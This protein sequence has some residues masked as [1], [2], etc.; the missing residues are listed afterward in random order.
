MKINIIWGK[1]VIYDHGR[2]DLSKTIG[3]KN[4]D[5]KDKDGNVVSELIINCE[6]K[7]IV[8]LPT[9]Y[10][11]SQYDIE[12]DDGILDFAS[13]LPPGDD[14][15][16]SDGIK[17]SELPSTKDLLPSD[18]F[19]LS[20]DEDGNGSYDKTLHVTF[21][22]LVESITPTPS[23]T[24]TVND[25][26]V[27][28]VSP[29]TPTTYFEGSNVTAQ[30]N[31]PDNYI[32]DSWV[33]DWEELNGNQS[34]FLNFVMPPQDITL[35]P[36]IES[37]FT[38]TVNS[39][40]GGQVSPSTPQS[41]PVGAQASASVIPSSEYNFVNWVSDWANIDGSTDTNL[42]F[43]M[44]E[45]NVTLTPLL[46]LSDASQWEGLMHHSGPS[47]D[48]WAAWDPNFK[49]WTDLVQKTADPTDFPFFYHSKDNTDP[50]VDEIYAIILRLENE[51]D[52]LQNDLE[53]SNFDNL[54][55]E[56]I[57]AADNVIEDSNNQ[58][59]SYT[60]T[61]LNDPIDPIS[62]GFINLNAGTIVNPVFLGLSNEKPDDPK[63]PYVAIQ[64]DK[65]HDAIRVRVTHISSGETI[66]SPVFYVYSHEDPIFGLDSI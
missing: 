11:E 16:D 44:P 13:P 41:Y 24:L 3:E 27:G 66:I 42:A 58:A 48:G 23:Y 2:I 19:A 35:T 7:T 9:L 59:M 40:D 26:G 64:F 18:I 15:E 32:F 61:G 28:S 56:Y 12:I 45:Q 39:V 51:A 54:K 4:I 53:S 52:W 25:I 31:V 20:R 38:L 6:S 62:G 60:G 34:P 36:T 10:F 29:S 63:S 47:P 43:I 46:V 50:Q 1:Y 49:K 5:I 57:D 55:V 65:T 22:D 8:K 37:L 30:I 14:E 21:N 17:I 33:S